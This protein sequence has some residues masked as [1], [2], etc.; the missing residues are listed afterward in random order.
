MSA[1]DR[2]KMRRLVEKE[3]GGKKIE[4]LSPEERQKVFAKVRESMGAPARGAGQG[5]GQPGQGG[6][7][8][9]PGGP[10]G[11]M[12]A[13]FPGRPGAGPTEEERN[14][15]KLPPP[16]EEDS[17]LQVLLRPGLLSDIE[18]IVE[19]IPN[20]VYLPAQAVFEKDGKQIVYV[21]KGKRFE[22]RVVKLAKRSESTMVITEGAS[23]GDIVALADPYGGSGDK[24]GKGQKKAPSAAPMMPGGGGQR[25]G[26]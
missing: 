11:L 15:A 18:I 7:R 5:A 16:P 24:K 1:E 17:Q 9:G 6:G 23:E 12:I 8:R 21:M 3:L 10:D 25:G 4:D 20:A 2:E 26:G 14:R 22:E 13:G 19:K